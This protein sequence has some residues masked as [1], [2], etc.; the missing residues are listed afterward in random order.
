MDLGSVVGSISGILLIIAAIFFAGDIH[1]FWNVPGVMIVLGGTVSTTLLT[2]QFKDVVTA[3][4][5]A[6]FA[7]TMKSP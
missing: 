3:F 6:Y 1:N 2:F 5:A 4:R 7:F